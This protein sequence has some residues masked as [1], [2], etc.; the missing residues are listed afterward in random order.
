MRFYKFYYSAETDRIDKTNPKISKNDYFIDLTN[1]SENSGCTELPSSLNLMNPNIHNNEK[2]KHS[3]TSNTTC[4]LEKCKVVS[5]RKKI[6]SSFRKYSPLTEANLQNRSSSDAKENKKEN[7][8]SD[9]FTQTIPSDFE[10]Y[11]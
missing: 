2:N 3:S 10:K 11:Y 5:K 8:Q 6:N 9:E 7:R 4:V 1:S